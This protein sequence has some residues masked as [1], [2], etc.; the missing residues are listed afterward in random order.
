MNPSPLVSIII[1]VRDDWQRLALCLQGIRA[2]TLRAEMIE[3]LVVDNGPMPLDHTRRPRD[4]LYLHHPEGFAYAARNAGIAL[5]RG[6]YLAFTD[7]DCLPDPNWLEAAVARMESSTVDLLAGA[8]EIFAETEN[9]YTHYERAFAFR[10]EEYV[11]R[12]GAVTAN[13]LVRRKVVGSV[14]PFDETL[15]TAGDFEFCRR[16]VASGFSLVYEPSARIRHPARQTANALLAKARRDAPGGWQLFLRKNPRPGMSSKARFL[17]PYFKPRWGIWQRQISDAP[18][19]PVQAALRLKLLALR[20]FMHWAT[21]L[22]ALRYV[23]QTRQT[24]P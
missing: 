16:A 4:A 20:L 5:A 18:P 8:V 24:A 17:L 9:L 23:L 2:Q 10:Q 22:Y 12:G 19:P 13:L 11:A 3:T 7:S 15:E 6:R 1:P 14:G 21:A